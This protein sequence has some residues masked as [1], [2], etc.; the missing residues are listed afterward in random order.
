MRRGGAGGW[1]GGDA[2]AVAG[3]CD[4]A[5][6]GQK[7]E[8]DGRKAVHGR[9]GDS[10]MGGRGRG[11]PPGRRRWRS[12]CRDGGA[13]LDDTTA[14]TVGDLFQDRSKGLGGV[15][16]GNPEG[17]QVGNVQGLAGA[18]NLRCDGV[19]RSAF[20]RVGA[21]SILRLTGETCGHLGRSPARSVKGCPLCGRDGDA[22]LDHLR[23]LGALGFFPLLGLAKHGRQLVREGNGCGCLAFGRRGGWECHGRQFGGAGGRQHVKRNGD[24]ADIAV[25]GLAGSG[26]CSGV[27]ACGLVS[28]G[29]G[30][31]GGGAGHVCDLGRCAAT[32]SD[33]LRPSYTVRNR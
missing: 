10:G 17:C 27:A 3:G 33:R 2:V 21:G 18:Q 4:S 26:G 13:R 28:G 1:C 14:G 30:G 15:P 20:A 11:R 31:N 29:G 24:G 8:C 9:R 6:K 7:E 32:V 22:G 23:R 5:S 16:G 12:G 25:L 19:D